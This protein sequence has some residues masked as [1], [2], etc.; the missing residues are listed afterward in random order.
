[1]IVFSS[2]ASLQAAR[3]KISRLMIIE[4]VKC[5]EETIQSFRNRKLRRRRLDG[6][7]LEVVTITEDSDIIIV[8]QYWL[9]ED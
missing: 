3:R 4:T 9:D 2:H 5:P 8:T 7:I 1:M 6:K